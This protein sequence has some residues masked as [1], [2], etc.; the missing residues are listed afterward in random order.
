M[1]KTRE[2]L[3]ALKAWVYENVCKGKEMKT[4]GADDATTQTAE[5]R[6]FVGTYPHR[7]NADGAPEPYN[8]APSILIVPTPSYAMLVKEERFDR[9][10]NIKREQQMGG[11]LS[12]EFI[13][14]VYD[15]GTRNEYAQESGKASDIADNGDDGFYTM[16]DWQ[17]ELKEKLLGVKQMPG[18][19]LFVWPA[20]I[21][22]GPHMVQDS[23]KDDWPLYL[24]YVTLTLGHYATEAEGMNDALA[25]ILDG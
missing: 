5:P 8:T 23:M 25:Q 17:D 2:R 10:A 4:P 20:S 22:Y 6:C 12:V 1:T 16:T 15:P 18:T 19:D 13:L 24:G 21:G 7:L 14:A 9:Y 3:E 11:Q